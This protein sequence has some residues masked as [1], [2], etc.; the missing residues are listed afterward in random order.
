MMLL[1]VGCFRF[2]QAVSDATMALKNVVAAVK[3]RGVQGETQLLAEEIW[4]LMNN[5]SCVAA[6]CEAALQKGYGRIL[7]F[8]WN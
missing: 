6:L 8:P 4:Y 7:S 2:P 5:A 1:T 3:D